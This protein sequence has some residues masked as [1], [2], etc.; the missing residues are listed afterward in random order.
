MAEG[1]E[2]GG[3]A[4]APVGEPLVP[5]APTPPAPVLDAPAVPPLEAATS[6]PA[7]EPLE[8]D[9][10]AA[11]SRPSPAAQKKRP[12]TR[13]S[14]WPH[15]RRGVLCAAL[16]FCLCGAAG[17]WARLLVWREAVLQLP[18]TTLE[19]RTQPRHTALICETVARDPIPWRRQRAVELLE[20][21]TFDEPG[22]LDA[23]F[24]ALADP[25]PGIEDAA[26][27]A[28][29]T[30]RGADL[31]KR[32]RVRLWMEAIP[33]KM[34]LD[35]FRHANNP[36]VRDAILSQLWHLSNDSFLTVARWT[37]VHDPDPRSTQE[38]FTIV[39]SY[40]PSMRGF[41]R[42]LTAEQAG[43]ADVLREGLANPNPEIRDDCRGRLLTAAHG[44]VSVDEALA[45]VGDSRN[46]GTVVE[47]VREL[48]RVESKEWEAALRKRLVSE[49]DLDTAAAIAREVPDL[50]GQDR[51]AEFAEAARENPS[52]DVRDVYERLFSP[53]PDA[54]EEV[55]DGR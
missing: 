6:A 34:W 53:Q 38:F 17:W 27:D 7:D 43:L 55:P 35:V 44:R 25:D 20:N 46:G 21:L 50:V 12:R 15:Y 3:G 48:Q 41:E 24:H 33:A 49:T 1:P 5:A 42:T 30:L 2:D 23:L 37:L 31:P 11:P 52:A 16:A 4:P 29:F 40:L 45:W 54:P 36:A 13:P 51:L 39:A 8:V 19:W 22:V 26:R 32:E 10:V 9:P 18:G 47:A 14:L 28:V